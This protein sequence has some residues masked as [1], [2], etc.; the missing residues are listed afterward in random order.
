M[1]YILNIMIKIIAENDNENIEYLKEKLNDIN[2]LGVIKFTKD[3]L[4]IEN[5]SLHNELLKR[6][7]HNLNMLI[8]K[9][10]NGKSIMITSCI[11]NEG[12]THTAYN[13]STFLASR[14]EKVI[15]IGTDIRNPD[16]SKLFDNKNVNPYPFISFEQS[17][18]FFIKYKNLSKSVL[19]FL[20]F[21]D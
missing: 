5:K 13:L 2:F 12:K 6:I 21:F 18:S 10:E 17:E 4:S 8:P 1:E 14:G 9:S 19:V 16:L 11:K 20:F 7:Y 15:I 3:N